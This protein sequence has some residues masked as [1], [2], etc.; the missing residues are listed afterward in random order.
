VGK[1]LL[2]SRAQRIAANSAPMLRTSSKGLVGIAL[3]ASQP[4]VRE[5]FESTLLPSIMISAS[6]ILASAA[7]TASDR[8]QAGQREGNSLRLPGCRRFDTATGNRID[9]VRRLAA[10]AHQIDGGLPRCRFASARRASSTRRSGPSSSSGGFLLPVGPGTLAGFR[11]FCLFCLDRR[12][13]GI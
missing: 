12:S 4:T 7:A 5:Q 2:V 6:R 8:T 11:S 1:D 9:P 13:S 10:E 3:A